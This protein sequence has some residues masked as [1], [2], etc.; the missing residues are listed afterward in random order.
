MDAPDTTRTW[1]IG[2]LAG[3]AHV[4]VRTL[5]HYEAIGL[6]PPTARTTP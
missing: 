4:S 2:E 5:R 1:R 3:M 6:L